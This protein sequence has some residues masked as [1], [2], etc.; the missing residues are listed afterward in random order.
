[1]TNITVETPDAL[2]KNLDKIMLKIAHRAERKFEA[3]GLSRE[4]TE[5]FIDIDLTHSKCPLDLRGLLNAKEQDFMHD[6]AG[7]Y[8]H[9]NRQT[10]ELENYFVPRYARSNHPV[11]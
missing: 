11:K 5:W 6:L 2:Q 8:N 7:I 1:M 9:L 3:Q 4:Y 10:M